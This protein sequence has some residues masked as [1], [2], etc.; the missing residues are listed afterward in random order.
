LKES[1]D[2]PGVEER[3]RAMMIHFR[4]RMAKA[5]EIFNPPFRLREMAGPLAPS[6][7]YGVS[8]KSK[9]LT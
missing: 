4:A 1:L 9:P 2:P 3:A 7:T 8:G 6:D 5:L